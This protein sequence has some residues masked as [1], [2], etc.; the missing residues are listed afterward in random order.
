VQKTIRIFVIKL[1]FF[2]TF[3]PNKFIKICKDSL[4]RMFRSFLRPVAALAVLA[5]LA[6]YATIMLRGPQGLNALAEKHRQIRDLQEENANLEREIGAKKQRIQRLQSD[7]ATQ[8]VEL[9]K[10]GFLHRHDT[11]FK[12]AGQRVDPVT[13]AAPAPTNGQKPAEH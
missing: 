4:H 8:E 1:C 6:A 7:P 3:A 2:W 9:E 10:L 13:G 5:A 12:V 11:Q